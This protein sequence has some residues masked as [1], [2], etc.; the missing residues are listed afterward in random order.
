MDIGIPKETKDR[1][2]RVAI[3]PEGVVRLVGQG[4]RVKVET[5][6]GEG[7]GYSDAAYSDAGAELVNTDSAWASELVVKVK[8]PLATEYAFLQGQMLFT[9]LHLSGVDRNLTIHLLDSKTLSIAYETV[10]DFQGRLPMLAPM[11][12]IAGN[13]AITMGCYYLAKFNRGNGVQLGKVMGVKQGKVIILGDGVVGKHAAAT[14]IGMGTE[15]IVL[16]KHASGGRTL[17]HDISDDL[18]FMQATPET[19]T[20][21]LPKA[22]LVVGAVMIRGAHAPRIVTEKMVKTMQPGSVIVDVSIDQGGCIETSRPTSHS[23]SVYRK[24]GV[25]H[26]CV[27]NMPGAYPRTSTQAL[28]N[29]TL[30]YIEKIANGGESLFR[31]DSAFT[32]GV[33]TRRG[34]LTN[35][36]VAKEL[37]MEDKYR[38]VY[39][40]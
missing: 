10:E 11:S 27:T 15:V 8:E 36:A 23:K 38:S 26:Y 37:N 30:P 22:D 25:I 32:K 24:H 31:Q 7:S 29:A 39:Q 18:Q 6:A 3:T 19:L 2:N 1:E 17:K 28:T 5:G 35:L 16:G 33:N 40:T 4:H 20:E 34:W 14:A 13:M 9:F 12:A 21:L